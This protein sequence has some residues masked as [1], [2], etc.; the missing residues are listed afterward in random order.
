MSEI[1]NEILAQLNP[2][3]V[4]EAA[5]VW[6]TLQVAKMM[7][8]GEDFTTPT[9]VAGASASVCGIQDADVSFGTDEGLA[10]LISMDS[11]DG[12]AFGWFHLV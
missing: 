6:L 8:V 11:G 1:S 2:D 5:K 12:E 10:V 3:D 9:V 7:G 4:R